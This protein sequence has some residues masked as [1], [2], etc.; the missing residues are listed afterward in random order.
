[1]NINELTIGQVKEILA[2]FPVA[3]GKHPYEI[4][5]NYFVRTV[6]YHLTG[7]LVSVYQNELVF[8]SAAWIADSGRFQD[9]L[10]SCEFSE[11]EMFPLVSV[12]VG[13]GSIVDC[14]KID[15]LPNRQK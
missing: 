4:G 14:C 10:A 15:S 8:E 12:V 9:S 3:D 5:A 1:M 7:K 11:V 13:R 6:T 2:M